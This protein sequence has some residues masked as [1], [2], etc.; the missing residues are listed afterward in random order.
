MAFGA[1]LEPIVQPLAP[2]V[3]GALRC[4]GMGVA[5]GAGVEKRAAEMLL[6]G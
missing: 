3:F 6:T 4:N 5:L 1:E 2:G